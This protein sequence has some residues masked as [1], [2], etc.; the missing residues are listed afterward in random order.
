MEDLYTMISPTWL[1][2]DSLSVSS[3]SVTVMLFTSA[4][5]PQ[6]GYLHDQR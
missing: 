4:N 2:S 1:M 3:V 6:P 5:S